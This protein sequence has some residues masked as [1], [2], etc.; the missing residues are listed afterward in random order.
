M[1]SLSSDDESEKEDG[2]SSNDVEEVKENEVGMRIERSG[3][4]D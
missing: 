3:D 4:T 1:V 2:S